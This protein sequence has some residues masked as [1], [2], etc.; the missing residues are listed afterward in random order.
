[1]Q[2]VECSY[3]RRPEGYELLGGYAQRGENS[4]QLAMPATAPCLMRPLARPKTMWYM[5]PA[6]H[7]PLD[8]AATPV[9]PPTPLADDMLACKSVEQLVVAVACFSGYAVPDVVLS[10]RDRLIAS[11]SEAGVALAAGA[12]ASNRSGRRALPVPQHATKRRSASPSGSTCQMVLDGKVQQ[13]R[14]DPR[15]SPGI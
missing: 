2:V 6:P 15:K 13:W 1:M 4:A 10:A 3:E 8:P 5:L 9:P 14:Q 11:L 7:T 12:A